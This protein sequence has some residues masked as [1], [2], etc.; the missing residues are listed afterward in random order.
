M[1]ELNLNIDHFLD[2]YWQKKPT[3]LKQAFIDFD[4]PIMAD[5]ILGLAMEEEVDSLLVYQEQDKWQVESGPFASFEK[6]ESNAASLLIQAANHWHEEVQTLIRPFRFFPN[7]R[8]NDLMTSYSTPGGGIGPHINNYDLFIIQGMGKSHWRIGNKVPRQEFPIHGALKHCQTFTAILDVNLEP[9]DILYIPYHYPHQGDAIE[10]S[11]NYSLALTAPDQN[12]LLSSFADYCIDN[13]APPLRYT[14]TDMQV[15]EKPGQIETQ[16]LQKL[17]RLMLSNC[18]TP[19]ALIPWLG[20]MI[21]DASHEL[22]IAEPEEPHSTEEILKLF[23]EGAQF[24]RL[25]GLRAVYFQQQ[26]Q[27]LFINGEKFNC[28]GFT[29]LSHHLCDQDEVGS[30]LLE[31][32]NED[33]QALKLFTQLVNIGYWYAS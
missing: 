2:T 7:W 33:P 1:F 20:C 14:D 8:I 26:P 31:L 6:L 23:A 5:E 22:D 30:E 15:R 4:D 10:G 9:G 21:S 28:E 18:Q 32:L 19:E 27:S 11:I 13:I 16:E 3:V 12:E 29:E 24:T 25:G 17:H